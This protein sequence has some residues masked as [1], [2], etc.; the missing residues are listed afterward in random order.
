MA[1]LVDR[2]ECDFP[3]TANNYFRQNE[4]VKLAPARPQ[5]GQPDCLPVDKSDFER[6]VK[7]DLSVHPDYTECCCVC[8]DLIVRS[9]ECQFKNFIRF[10][11]WPWPPPTS[12]TACCPEHRPRPA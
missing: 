12:A 6:P 2:A 1:L 8:H 11:L 3:T 10:Y 7:T 5:V 4:P 9:M